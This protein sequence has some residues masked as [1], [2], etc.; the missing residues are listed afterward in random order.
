[1]PDAIKPSNPPSGGETSG[2]IVSSGALLFLNQILVSAGGWIFWIIVPRFV[3]A[4]EVGQATSVY[5]LVILIVTF[6]QL[7]FEYPL[8]RRASMPGQRVFGTVLTIEMILTA[9]FIPFAIFFVDLFYHES[10]MNYLDIIIITLILSPMGFVSRFALMGITD[11]KTVF[12]SALLGTGVKLLA[13]FMLVSFGYGV[14]GILLAFLISS[15]VTTGWTMLV[16]GKNLGLKIGNIAFGKEVM[17]ESF[18]NAPSKLS[19]TVVF[20]LIIVMLAAIGINDSDIGIFYIALMISVIAGGLASSIS[21]MVIP[22]ST[23]IKSDLSLNGARFGMNLTAPLI[24]S[25]IVAPQLFLSLI[26]ENYKSADMSLLVLSIAVLPSIIVT[27]GIAKFNN[28]GNS[29]KLIVIGIIQ[30][31]VFLSSFFVF[32]P[33][34]GI[35]GGALAI[36]MAFTASAIP[37]VVWSEK[38]LVKS[39]AISVVSIMA[40]VAIG[41]YV[42]LVFSDMHQIIPTVFAFS[43]TF[44]LIVLSKGISIHEIK[45]LLRASI[46]NSVQSNHT[47]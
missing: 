33:A 45:W 36:L 47:D 15:A 39:I 20:S 22:V 7:G 31:S 1:M 11:V 40:G 4:A 46:K 5:N 23:R 38:P 21:F 32:V 18:A 27:N 16:A 3:T 44:I 30:I 25:L 35:E 29:T 19:R 12:F 24:S 37:I 10:S 8:L 6:A 14:F 41:E 43:G 9:A 34:A 13:G 42:E 17:K 28:I 2:K 26:G